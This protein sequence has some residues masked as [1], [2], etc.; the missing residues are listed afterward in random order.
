MVRSHV[1]ISQLYFYISVFAL[2][3]GGLLPPLLFDHVGG[4]LGDDHGGGVG[5]CR[6]DCGHD[7]RVHHPDGCLVIFAIKW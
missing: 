5:V 4:L 2:C 1:T 7:A 6:D 3:L